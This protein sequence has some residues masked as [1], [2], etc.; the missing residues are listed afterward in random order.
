MS[1]KLSI[2]DEV[3]NEEKGRLV[4]KLNRKM[5]T[6]YV[7]VFMATLITIFISL[8]MFMADGRSFLVVLPGIILTLLFVASFK[9][10]FTMF[11]IIAST[12][13]L[14]IAYTFAVIGYH[15][16]N[17][18]S[19]QNFTEVFIFYA[20][21]SFIS[22]LLFRAAFAAKKQKTVLKELRNKINH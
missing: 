11:L 22:Y 20:I 19:L 10:P 8:D 1:T 13:A 9:W 21:F 3:R 2:F 16:M 7:I 14:F 5:M 18:L 17:G 6:G 12:S 4:M 15:N